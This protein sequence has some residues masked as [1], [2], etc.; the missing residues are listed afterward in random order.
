MRTT[1]QELREYFKFLD[2]ARVTLVVEMLSN[3]IARLLAECGREVLEANSWKIPSTYD[4]N[5][6][7][8]RGDV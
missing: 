3:W 7:N 5:R 8:D 2:P 1:A 6:K 4:N